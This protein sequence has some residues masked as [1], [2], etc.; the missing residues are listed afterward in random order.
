MK[1][2]IIGA[3]AAVALTLMT[4]AS[5]PAV[6]AMTVQQAAVNI[7]VA[8]GGEVISPL[9][10]G[11]NTA[12]WDGNLVSN[13]VV[14]RL[15]QI[16]IK[17][18]R[19]PGG[20]YA[21]TF[22]FK[23]YTNSFDQ[24]M[25]LSKQVG[26][27]PL[28]TVNY[29]SGTP[30]EAASWVAYTKAH[31]ETALWEIGNEIYGNGTYQNNAWETDLHSPKGPAAYAKN[32]LAFITAMK[33]V[34]KNAQ[35]GVVATIPGVWPSGIAPYWDR[36]MLPIVGKKI[37][38]IVIHWYAQNPGQEDDATL[39]AST[40]T[41]PAYMSQLHQYLQKYCGANAKHIQIFLDETN[42][43]SSNP[44]KQVMSVV[45]ALF[46]ANDYNQWLQNGVQNVSWWD[47]HNGKNAGN[48]SPNL[49]G[50]ATYGDYGILSNGDPG[51]PPINTPTASFWGLRMMDLFAQPRD[52]YVQATSNQLFLSAYAVKSPKNGLSFM[53]VNTSPDTAYAVSLKG[54]KTS[55]TTWYEQ[56]TYGEQGTSITSQK[57]H[58]LGNR[59]LVGPYSMVVIKA[60]RGLAA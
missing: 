40:S 52:R 51:E 11:M 27:V 30:S 59:L 39:L 36:T 10:Y 1:K 6:L 21:D 55:R 26:A 42:S 57:T 16:G 4:S 24:F 19:F 45:N 5:I 15:K 49:F 29:G 8:H 13:T 50:N 34:D 48:V 22:H 17:L 9:A 44:G 41:I 53:L 20:S 43:V 47:L 3:V 46:A 23:D 18:L 7:N 35:I 28:L 33:K 37:D 32:A 2:T 38:F 12:V 56:Y 14:Q 58:M 25:Q 54:I 31:H 60:Q